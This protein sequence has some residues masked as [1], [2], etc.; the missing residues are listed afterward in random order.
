MLPSAS[1]FPEPVV[2][3]RA[4]QPYVFMRRSVTW[5]GFAD[6]ADRLPELV[7]WL[8]ARGIEVADAPFFRFNTVAM[9]G[10]SEVEAGV[11]VASPLPEPEGDIGVA[12][13][14]AGRYATLTHVGH[15]ERLLAAAAAL[16]EWADERGLEW[17]MRE[18][19]GVERWGC[20]IEAYRTDPRVEPDPSRWE[21]ELAF[22][23]SD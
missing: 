12:L 23:L 10:E 14:P 21:T 5:D 15:P 8:A 22:R 2:V 16:R 3:E 18:V 1:P 11:P 6:I 9:A 19:D 17:D 20:R 4:E 7:G 13:L